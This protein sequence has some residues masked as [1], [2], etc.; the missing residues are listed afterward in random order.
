[1]DTKR[2]EKKYMVVIIDRFSKLVSLSSTNSQDE[3]T[4]LNV[5]LNNWIY[6]FGRPESILTDRGRIFE[7]SMFRD[8]MSKFGIK[9]EFSSPYQHQSN[10]LAERVIRT[11]RDMLATSLTGAGLENNW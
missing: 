6:K 5:I 1:M 9:Q 8:W 2:S 3:S 7:G 11:V 4:I 10:G